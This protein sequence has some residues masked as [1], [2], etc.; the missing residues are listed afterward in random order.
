[1]SYNVARILLMTPIV[2]WQNFTPFLGAAAHCSTKIDNFIRQSQNENHPKN[3][4]NLKTLGYTN[5]EDDPKMNT[6]P[7]MKTIPKV[8]TTGKLKQP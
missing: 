3:E 2:P 1:M 6:N 8:M 7:K 5:W 4:D